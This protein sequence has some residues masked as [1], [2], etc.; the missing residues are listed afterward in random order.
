MEYD[1]HLAEKVRAGEATLRLYRWKPYCISLGANQDESVIAVEKCEEDGIEFV[2]RPTGG[3]AILHAEELTYSVVM[4]CSFDNSPQKIYREIN[5]ALLLGLG[6]YDGKLTS[7][8]LEY[9]QPDFAAIYRSG[10]GVACFAETAKNELKYE[11]KKLI[12]SAQRKIGSVVLQ[13]GS[14]LCGPFHRKL[15]YYLHIHDN[16]RSEMLNELQDKTIEI[17]TILHAA[18]DYDRLEEAV[19]SGFEKYFEEKF[20][21]ITQIE[22]QSVLN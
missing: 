2:K 15:P 3:R 18:V 19:I 21:R 16:E 5:D 12:G 7:A 6:A 4:H 9:K 13:H 17:E 22:S 11:H 20:D 1:L 8:E 14:I 10:K